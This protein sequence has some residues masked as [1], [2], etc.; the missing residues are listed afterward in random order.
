MLPKDIAKRV[1]KTHLMSESE[2]RNLGVQQSQGWVHYMI[3]QPDDVV[4]GG[5]WALP[6]LLQTL[7]FLHLLKKL[8]L[9]LIERSKRQQW[10]HE[11]QNWTTEQWKKVAWS[12]ESHFLLH[13]VD[14]RV[15]VRLLPGK[16]MVPGCTMGRRRAGRGSVMLWAMFCWE[17][18]GPAV[19]VDVTV[20]RSTDLSIAADHVHLFM[21]TLF[22]D[23]CGLFQQDNVACHKSKLVQEWFDDHNNQF[24]VLTW[25]PLASPNLNPIHHLWGVLDKQVLSKDL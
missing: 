10:V 14:G 19:H 6:F 13:H 3:H 20:T 24:E 12:D 16:H 25:R 22:P 21:E 4:H 7:L 9:V 2:W 23:G 15:R 8:M 1:P 11:H 18:L 17:I 5:S